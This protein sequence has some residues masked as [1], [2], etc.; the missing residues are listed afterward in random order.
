[1]M[2]ETEIE[3]RATEW[4]Q[5]TLGLLRKSTTP[6][7]GASHLIELRSRLYD[8]TSVHLEQ[9]T[10]PV[11]LIKRFNNVI[12]RWEVLAQVSCPRIST[13]DKDTGLAILIH[14]SAPDSAR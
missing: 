1:M 8:A 14:M 7:A 9:D 6:E 11:E 12:E 10:D 3:A 13:F 2:S 5:I 4:S